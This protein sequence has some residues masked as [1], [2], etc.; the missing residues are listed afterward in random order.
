[1]SGPRWLHGAR[2]RTAMVAVGLRSI[3]GTI[4]PVDDPLRGLLRRRQSGGVVKFLRQSQNVFK[5]SMR[6]D[7]DW[8]TFDGRERRELV[9]QG[10]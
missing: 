10:P 8:P 9:L 3:E 7:T 2:H 6:N 1:M 4:D 5:E